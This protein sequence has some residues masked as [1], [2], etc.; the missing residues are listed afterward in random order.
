ML[1]LKERSVV[2]TK[3]NQVKIWDILV[4]LETYNPLPE[5]ALADR[6]AAMIHVVEMATEMYGSLSNI[7]RLRYDFWKQLLPQR[8]AEQQFEYT[9]KVTKTYKWE[10]T[11]NAQGLYYKD[12]SGDYTSL[13]GKVSEQLFSDF[14]FYGPLLPIPD[15][16][17]RKQLIAT[18][19]N[20]FVQAGSPASYK[21]FDLFEYPTQSISPLT[22]DDGDHNVNDFVILRDYGIEYGRTN[23]HDGL[24]FLGYLS[25]EHFLT[26]PSSGGS[27]ITPEIRAE[28]EE[29][30]AI[31]PHIESYYDPATRFDNAESKRLFM[32]NGGQVHY[33][34]L[35]GF[36]DVYDA[37]FIEEAIWRTELIE[38]YKSRLTEEDNEPT[39]KHIARS[40]ELNGVNNVDEILFEAVK[41]ASPKGKQ[42]LAK[43]LVEQYNA[44]LGAQSLLS[45]L[46]YETETDYWRNYVF[47]S[48]FNL[49]NNTTVQNFLIQKLRGDNEIH[50]NKSVDVLRAWSYRGD[51]TLADKDLLNALNWNDAT[52]NNKKFQEIL[53]KI[54]KIIQQK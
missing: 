35:D 20:A 49:R 33:I 37:T 27:Y 6:N 7:A 47:N 31:K 18:I 17:L 2:Q 30:L 16:H 36:G 3:D 5:E 22:W 46:Q 10:L 40:L 21:H 14:W 26:V 50:F 52:T 38:Q 9:T 48:F 4:L 23:W 32:E 54:I 42:V 28:I 39:L 44:D 12:I 24:V 1:E 11:I 41:M 8:I 13:Q 51:E 15:L 34:H 29:F 53:E 25:F 43:I 19:R 45:L